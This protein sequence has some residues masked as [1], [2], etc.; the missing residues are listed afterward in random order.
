MLREYGL[1]FFNTEKWNFLKKTLTKY[2]C[3]VWRD[4]GVSE[5]SQWFSQVSMPIKW[6]EQ[7]FSTKTF[8]CPEMFGMARCALHTGIPQV[9]QSSSQS[10]YIPYG[11]VVMKG[12]FL[13]SPWRFYI[14]ETFP[15]LF[16][17]PFQK[18]QTK[19]PANLII[20]IQ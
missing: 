17:M 8:K 2:G 9:T 13:D 6:S 4:R 5:H 11:V 16:I 14:L 12:T 20:G 19:P 18:L 7:V 1:S 3:R 15:K 10:F